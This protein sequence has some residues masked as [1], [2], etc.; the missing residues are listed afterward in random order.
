MLALF[1]RGNSCNLVSLLYLIEIE[2][3][4]GIEATELG[5]LRIFFFFILFIS[6]AT[7]WLSCMETIVFYLN[8]KFT[9]RENTSFSFYL[10][11]REKKI[12]W[13]TSR[14]IHLEEDSVADVMEQENSYTHTKTDIF[15]SLF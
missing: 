13:R 10:K 9:D 1:F 12:C 15:A 11:K 5:F 3:E 2:I 7:I 14:T 8:V 4:I 6:V